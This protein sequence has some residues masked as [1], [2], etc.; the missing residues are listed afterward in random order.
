M[1]ETIFINGKYLCSP[2]TGVQRYAIEVLK[3]IDIL[4]NDSAYK[5]IR[6]V[7]LAPKETR[8]QPAW[9]NIKLRHTGVAP[10]NIWEQ[11]E[12]PLYAHGSLLFSPANT[13]PVLYARQVITMH[14]A[15][16]FA[17]P[18]AYSIPFRAKY[19]IIFHIL[20]RFARRVLTDSAFSQKELA[21]NLGV[22][23]ERFQVIP[24]G[25][26]HMLDIIPDSSILEKHGLSKNSFLLS[27][28]SQSKHKN[29]ERIL[30]AESY[31][32]DG[33]I[34]AAAGGSN[35]KVFNALGK[36]DN[37]EKVK[38]LGYVTD[39]ELKALYENAMGFIFPSLYEGFGLPI[40]EAMNCGCP[41]LCSNAA[42]IREVAGNAGLYFNPLDVNDIARSITEFVSDETLRSNLQVSGFL[43]ASR[44][45]WA[46]T[47]RATLER[48]ITC[49]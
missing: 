37:Q 2:V 3:Q 25:G 33:L 31:L 47:A 48:L 4:L 45:T 21:H 13:G 6:M 14:D 44:F 12:L 35:Q 29:F 9:K 27:V 34:L 26:D 7:C 41:V 8:L 42:S 22:A 1:A 43:Q 17:I 24:L 46:L 36:P 18:D 28:A 49:L 32:G 40:L 16:V 38:H 11:F 10:A 39:A 5:N 20:A 15:A 23:L 30:Q 19:F